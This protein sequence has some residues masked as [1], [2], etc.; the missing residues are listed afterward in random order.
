MLLKFPVM[1]VQVHLKNLFLIMCMFV[2]MR[3]YVHLSVGAL[4]G[5]RRELKLQEVVS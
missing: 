1:V 5:Q 2:S 3:G 4:N